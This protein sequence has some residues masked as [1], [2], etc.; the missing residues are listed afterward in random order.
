MVTRS[1]HLSNNLS[2]DIHNDGI[3]HL[4]YWSQ[5][6]EPSYSYCQGVDVVMFIDC[7]I[8]QEDKAKERRKK[9]RRKE[10]KK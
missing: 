2:Q 5:L 4:C 6:E 9:R 3:W 8:V 1:L 10:E 7:L